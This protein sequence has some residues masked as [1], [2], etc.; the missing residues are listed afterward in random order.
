[1]KAWLDF[2]NER[3]GKSTTS[4]KNIQTEDKRTRVTTGQS[5]PT[6]KCQ[7]VNE[8]KKKTQP[9][10]HIYK[11]GSIDNTSRPVLTMGRARTLAWNHHHVPVLATGVVHFLLTIHALSSITTL[12]R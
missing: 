5:M 10:A 8:R 11:H 7:K 6:N 9:K 4:S 12:G 1:M 2:S 3:V